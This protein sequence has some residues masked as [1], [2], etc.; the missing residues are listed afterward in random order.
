MKVNYDAAYWGQFYT[1]YPSN[2]WEYPGNLL[3]ARNF[4]LDLSGFQLRAGIR[5]RL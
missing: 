1:L 4:V 2:S 3:W 5:I